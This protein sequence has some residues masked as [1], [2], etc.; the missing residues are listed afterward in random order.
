MSPPIGRL[1]HAPTADDDSRADADGLTQRRDVLQLRVPLPVD[2]A[3]AAPT[4]AFVPGSADEDAWIAVNNRAF[5]GHPDQSGMTRSR[6]HVT[7]AEDWFDPEG[8]R[9]HEIDGRL[10]AFCW[11]KRHPAAAGEPA[12]GEIFVIG[13]DPDF[14]GRGLG[15]SLTLSG[16]EWLSAAGETTGMLYV[17]ATNAP[18]R[19]LYDA[20]GFQLHHIDRLYAEPTVN[21]PID[22]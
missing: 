16:L 20:L 8:F 5:A 10:A 21:S 7:L 14:Q 11:T 4:R 1:V 9:L 3:D 13:V 18:A 2:T 12:L 15:R 22:R 19:A 6:L 17:D